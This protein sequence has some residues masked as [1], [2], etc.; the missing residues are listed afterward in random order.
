M[1]LIVPALFEDEGDA[2]RRV[3]SFASL[4]LELDISPSS[5]SLL[6]V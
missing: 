6:C 4:G 2:L 1:S 3:M 5:F